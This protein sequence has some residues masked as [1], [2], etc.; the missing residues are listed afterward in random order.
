[1]SD[2]A[3]DA[4]SDLTIDL[5]FRAK[6]L[7]VGNLVF[8][9]LNGDGKFTEG[10]DVGVSNVVVR[11]LAQGSNP[12]TGE[13]LDQ[14]ITAVDGTFM[15]KASNPGN[16][17]LYIPASAFEAAGPLNGLLSISGFGAD[18]GA[19]DN[20]GENGLDEANPAANGVRSLQFALSYGDEPLDAGTESGFASTLD[21]TSDSDG[22]MTIDFG[23]MMPPAAPLAGMLRTTLPAPGMSSATDPESTEGDSNS[24]RNTSAQAITF[25]AWQAVHSLEGQNH[26]TD[27]PDGDAFANLAEYALGLR[28]DSGVLARA[29]FTLA[30][31]AETGSVDA[32]LCRPS[33]GREDVV[34]VLEGAA[35]PSATVWTPLGLT[36]ATTYAADGT[37]TQTYAAVHSAAVYAGASTGFVRLSIRLDADQNGTAEATVNSPVFA[38]SLLALEVGQQSFS[39]PL[40]RDEVFAG[41]VVTSEGSTLTFATNGESIAALFESGVSYYAEIVS[42]TQAGH[43]VEIDESA[44]TADSI[45]MDLDSPLSTL[46]TAPALAA[47]TRVIVRPHQTTAGIFG[48]D[49]LASTDSATT[50]DRLLFFEEGAYRVLW[51]RD[52]GVG[53]CLD[54]GVR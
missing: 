49:L 1:M 31:N 14:A 48:T 19:D 24:N 26:A 22:D 39:M 32:V 21:N 52:T 37:R 45:A 42:G 7:L 16:Y 17:F 38:W 27:N 5:G 13:V 6:P 44:S 34:F 29:P 33:T 35:S 23:F 28:P 9:D 50:A 46:H 30:V 43:R 41:S 10:T 11:L 4:E 15:L 25:A 47:G 18:N 53:L 20:D 12:V 54:L 36:P 40:L 8:Q 51:L 2:D 3:A